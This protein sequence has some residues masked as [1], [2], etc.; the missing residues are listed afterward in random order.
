[1]RKQR[2]IDDLEDDSSLV[3]GESPPPKITP[4]RRRK[5]QPLAD[6][7]IN[8]SR[9]VK[10]KPMA[11]SGKN[12][13]QA[14]KMTRIPT[15][16]D[17]PNSPRASYGMPPRYSPT[18]Q[19]NLE[20]NLLISDL[21]ARDRPG[22]FT[23]FHE[24]SPNN[25]GSAAAPDPQAPFIPPQQSYVAA[26]GT[27]LSMPS[28][29]WLQPPSQQTSSYHNPHMIYRP[30]YGRRQTFHDISIGQENI[31]SW[32]GQPSEP[33]IFNANP[34]PWVDLL[35]APYPVFFDIAE[36]VAHEIPFEDTRN[37]LADAPGPLEPEQDRLPIKERTTSEDNRVSKHSF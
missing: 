13:N 5:R 1:V 30:V 37:P 22:N 2:H 17:V 21:P 9:L 24:V 14:G 20:S 34:L 31:P 32:I 8:T 36:G 35:S 18:E 15:I 27:Q 16:T 12:R 19:E 25:T 11:A 26:P 4:N 33:G 6:I 29:S 28:A 7:S 23:I 3:E 10:Q